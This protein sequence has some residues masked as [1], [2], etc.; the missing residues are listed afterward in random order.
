MHHRTAFLH[1]HQVDSTTYWSPAWIVP[2]LI[3]VLPFWFS[4]DVNLKSA[5]ILKEEAWVFQDEHK[6]IFFQNYYYFE[7]LKI[8][9]SPLKYLYYLLLLHFYFSR[10]A[11]WPRSSFYVNIFKKTTECVTSSQFIRHGVMT[12]F[13]PFGHA[14]FSNYW[15]LP[16]FIWASFLSSLFTLLFP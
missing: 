6:L 8:H 9:S 15:F 2:D 1:H 16:L 14:T 12:F 4:I 3:L 13:I 7:L 5:Y 10:R 11:H